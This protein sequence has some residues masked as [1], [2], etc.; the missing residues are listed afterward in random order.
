MKRM[1]KAIARR[2]WGLTAPISRPIARKVSARLGEVVTS[3]I[4][5]EVHPGIAHALQGIGVMRSEV[6]TYRNETN[7]LLDALVREVSRLQDEMEMLREELA[8]RRA[9]VVGLGRDVSDAA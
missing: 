1:L 4:R 8:A 2:G 7:L 3:A 6:G 5:D 9:P